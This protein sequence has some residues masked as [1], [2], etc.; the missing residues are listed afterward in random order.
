MGFSVNVIAFD[1]DRFKNQ[2]I[3]A[4]KEGESNSLIKNELEFL[5]KDSE[6]CL[7]PNESNEAFKHQFYGLEVVME[8]FDDL[9]VKSNIGRNFAVLNGQIEFID[10]SF[11]LP[12]KKHWGYEDLCILFEYITLKH[13]SK[14]HTNLGKEYSL[15]EFIPSLNIGMLS[16]LDNGCNFFQHGD[17]GFGEGITGWLNKDDTKSLFNSIK[18]I[19]F[20]SSKDYLSKIRIQEFTKLTEIA[21]NENLGILAG[22]DL[23]LSV[24]NRPGILKL[25]LNNHVSGD[26]CVNFN[27]EIVFNATYE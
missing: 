17:G 23:G 4:F 22:R 24:P 5:I 6:V 16:K 18:G 20:T 14:Y 12:S 27:G 11:H 7:L 19:D 9:L 3:P 8:T 1:F 13:C 26:T 21:V 2:I 10:S 25:E 15:A